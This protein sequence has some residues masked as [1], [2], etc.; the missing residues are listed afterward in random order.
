MFFIVAVVLLIFLPSPWRWV[1]FLAGLALF[2]VEVLAWNRTVRGKQRK[3]GPE[4]L[5]GQAATVVSA[6]APDGQVRVG[7]EIW[8]ARCEGGA[9]EGE[10][11]TVVGRKGLVLAVEHAVPGDAPVLE[12]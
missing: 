10:S 12:A 5:I 2:V 8:A 9:D 11:V 1:A 4:T 7:G 6:C 3:V